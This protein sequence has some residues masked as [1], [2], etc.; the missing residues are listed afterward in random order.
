MKT[1]AYGY[2]RLGERREFKTFIESYWKGELAEDDLTSKMARLEKTRLNSYSAKTDIFP[3]GEFTYY[4]NML[5]MALILG[6]LGADDLKQY[7]SYGRGKDA[8]EMKKFF[9]TN[10][11]YLVPTVKK[12]PG[13]KLAWNKPLGYCQ[14]F[15]KYAGQ[16]ASVIGPYT[17]LRLA[18]VEGDLDDTIK[19]LAEVYRKLFNEL[20]R[21]GYPDVHIEEPAFCLDV[22][23]KDRRLI[24]RTYRRMI[25]EGMNVNLVTYYGSVDFLDLLYKLPVKAIGLDFVSGKDNL[26]NLKKC[27]IPEG[28][29]LI[30]GVLDGRTPRRADLPA[31]I[32]LVDR[33]RRAAGASKD[34]IMV[35]N[36][37]PLFHLPVT[38]A[39]EKK[40]SG[41]IKGRLSFARERLHELDLMK[42]AFEGDR[43]P[44]ERWSRNVSGSSRAK[45]SKTYKTLSWDKRDIA[46]RRK[47][48][49]ELLDLD[50]FP[51]TTIGS[52][53]QDSEL[54][55]K[56]ARYR[57]GRL[58]RS[59]YEGFIRKKIKALI[60]KQEEIGL[61]V[62]V[63]GEFERTDMVEFFAQ[64]LKGCTTTSTGW[65]ISYGTRVYR[66][67]IIHDTVGRTCDL[68][69]KETLYAQ[70][71]TDRIVKGIFTGP[72]TILSWSYNLRDES[73][74]KVAFELAEALNKEAVQLVKKG[75]RIIQ[76]DEPAIREYAPLKSRDKARYYGWAV[77]SFNKAAELPAEVQVHTH[78]C[79][80]EFGQIIKEILAMNFDVI[81]IETAREEGAVIDVF[82]K[83][84]FKRQIGPGVWDIHSSVP[85]DKKTISNVLES[86]VKL[87]GEENIWVNP[88]CGLKT[89]GW[90]EV[91]ISLKRLVKEARS[92]RRA[93]LKG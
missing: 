52:F 61:D 70:S 71:L 6:V 60:R 74:E 42:R 31:A 37:A 56:R 48:Q 85:A 26:A 11:H 69:G 22:T 78:L 68:T 45:S 8:L 59:S 84:G 46:K 36:S 35:S 32:K 54:R 27:R 40:I 21:A 87:L 30:C 43:D 38:V 67:P 89:R 9:N 64:K 58:G 20:K 10:Y 3:V 1:Y 41:R 14:Y 66:P 17:F 72:V 92:R 19:K 5:D 65:V 4:D 51:T 83:A 93:A 50:L 33:I 44:A 28:K 91:D 80:S 86:A 39:N 82:K 29:S 12:R 34:Q 77:R 73:P 76:I 81:T 2:P 53:P 24:A 90:K 55:K 79:Y 47:V 75:I 13:F 63:H 16:P 18:K 57:K 7:F 25:P 62:L 15:E 88:D 23:K 49:E